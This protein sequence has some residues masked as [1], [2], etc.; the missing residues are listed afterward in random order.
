MINCGW[1][2]VGEI[3]YE[4][5]INLNVSSSHSVKPTCCDVSLQ[6]EITGLL[7]QRKMHIYGKRY[8]SNTDRIG[9]ILINECS[10]HG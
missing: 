7:M 9:Q 10:V 4:D 8:S 1:V 5:N 2:A 3:I 6:L